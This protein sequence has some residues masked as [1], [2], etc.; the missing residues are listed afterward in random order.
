V[1]GATLPFPLE[2]ADLLSRR[3]EY[4]LANNTFISGACVSSQV[5]ADAAIA[6]LADKKWEMVSL[7]LIPRSPLC[8]GEWL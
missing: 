2:V 6:C 5:W 8:E 1:P 4:A 7:S 3:A